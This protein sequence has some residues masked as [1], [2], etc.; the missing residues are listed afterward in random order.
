M[1]ELSTI[2]RPYAKATFE[3][4]RDA[5]DLAGWA[6]ALERIAQ[7]V[8]VDDVA[9]LLVSPKVTREQLAG[10]VIEAAGDLSGA[11]KSLV[12]LLAENG[13]LGAAT[14]LAAQFAVLK[15]ESEQVV[16]AELI[17]ARALTDTQRHKLVQ[18]LEKKLG[19]EVKVDT[20]IDESLI[21]GAIIRAGDL[22]IDGSV[23]SRLD[24]LGAALAH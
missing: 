24:K 2:A 5:G 12:S 13:R 10:L 3:V 19:R 6:A 17:S 4:A 1:A 16:N 14:E 8:A 11:Q 18:A 22:V 23:A 7:V 20:R 21:G 15:A 9:D